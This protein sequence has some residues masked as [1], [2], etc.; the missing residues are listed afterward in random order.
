MKGAFAN[1]DRLYRL[2]DRGTSATVHGKDHGRH[3]CSVRGV[4]GRRDSLRATGSCFLRQALKDATY[5]AY[6]CDGPRMFSSS[7]WQRSG[8]QAASYR[9]GRP[10]RSS[11]STSTSFQR[12]RRAPR[13]RQHHSSSW[14]PPWRAPLRR[15]VVRSRRPRTIAHRASG[16]VEF[17]G[18]GGRRDPCQAI[19]RASAERN[20]PR[21]T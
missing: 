1:C 15:R 4:A 18:R 14:F 21:F 5:A 20:P 2:R 12:V 6:V 11:P 9:P 8:R 10:G 16:Y 19:V 7:R 13:V 17:C 3:R